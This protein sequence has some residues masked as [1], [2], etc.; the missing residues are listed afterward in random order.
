MKN[1]QKSLFLVFKKTYL[2]LFILIEKAKKWE[3]SN[4]EQLEEFQKG[5]KETM[6]KIKEQYKGV[7]N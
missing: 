6:L 4:I 2:E 7:D 3:N 5:L 1:L